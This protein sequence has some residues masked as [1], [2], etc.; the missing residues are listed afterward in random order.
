[1][2]EEPNRRT[3][4]TKDRFSLLNIIPTLASG[5]SSTVPDYVADLIYALDMLHSIQDPS[6]FLRN[7][8]VLL[9]RDVS[10]S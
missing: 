4:E 8:T 2:K 9:S 5:Y 6:A 7:C 10:W 1:V 3:A